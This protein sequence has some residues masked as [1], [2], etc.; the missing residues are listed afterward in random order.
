MQEDGVTVGAYATEFEATLEHLRRYDKHCLSDF[1]QTQ[2]FVLG[3]NDH[4]RTYVSSL[5]PKTL[6]EAIRLAVTSSTADDDKSEGEGEPRHRQKRQSSGNAPTQWRQSGDVPTPPIH[7][8]GPTPDDGR[9]SER[10]TSAAA[11]P[12]R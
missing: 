1:M 10:S 12:T 9:N 2:L 8:E 6:E 4:T 3:L 7:A 11:Q 5:R